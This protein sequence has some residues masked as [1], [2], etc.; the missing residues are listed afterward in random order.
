MSDNPNFHHRRAVLLG[1]DVG[2]TSYPVGVRFAARVD[3]VDPGAI[4]GRAMGDTREAAERAAL[5]NAAHSL[6]LAASRDAL[7]AVVAHLVTPPR[8]A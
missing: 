3:N 7:K 1:K 2:I 5:E 8:K 6:E 4:I